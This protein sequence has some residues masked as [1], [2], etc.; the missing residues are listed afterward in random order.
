MLEWA[1]TR[2]GSFLCTVSLCRVRNHEG[3]DV[4]C[5]EFAK[6]RLLRDFETDQMSLR[7]GVWCDGGKGDRCAGAVMV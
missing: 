6:E 2:K 1:G 4:D 3:R 5:F 7:I